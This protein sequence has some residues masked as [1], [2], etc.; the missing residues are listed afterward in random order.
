MNSDFCEQNYGVKNRRN[1]LFTA[2][3]RSR[4]WT[5]ILGVGSNME[6]IS[7]E[8]AKIRKADFSLNFHYPSREVASK[9]AILADVIHD[10]ED[11]EEFNDLWLAA[12]KAKDNWPQLPDD[13]RLE[14]ESLSSGGGV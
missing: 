3:T 7:S 13:L 14:L 11:P 12:K 1:I 5:Y 10:D 9:L 6:K 4:A 2:I 8:L